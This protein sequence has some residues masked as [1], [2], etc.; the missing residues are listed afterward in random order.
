VEQEALAYL[1]LFLVQALEGP[2]AVAVALQQ[3][4]V[5]HRAAVLVVPLPALLVTMEHQ[6]LGGVE[7]EQIMVAAVP[8]A[9][10]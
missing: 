1:H 5:Q 4:V 2:V 8:A 3:Q 7:V 6:I 9:L 10:A